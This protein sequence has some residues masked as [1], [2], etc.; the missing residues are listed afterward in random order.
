MLPKVTLVNFKYFDLVK[1]GMEKKT[2]NVSVLLVI[3]THSS[4]FSVARK[5][6]SSELATVVSNGTLLQAYRAGLWKDTQ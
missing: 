1:Q 3:L 6:S 5:Y 2:M 4:G